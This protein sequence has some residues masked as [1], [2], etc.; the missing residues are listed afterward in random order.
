MHF[1]L[2][3][4]TT[5]LLKTPRKPVYPPGVLVTY[6]AMTFVSPGKENHLA[7]RQV[8]PFCPTRSPS[9][10]TVS[11]SSPF[12]TP[13]KSVIKGRKRK[14]KQRQFHRNCR[15]IHASYR[16][17]EYQRKYGVIKSLSTKQKRVEIA[18]LN[19]IIN[20]RV[21]VQ[22]LKFICDLPLFLWIGWETTTSPSKTACAF[23]KLS[24]FANFKTKQRQSALRPALKL[25]LGGEGEQS[26]CTDLKHIVVKKHSLMAKLRDFF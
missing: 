5:P 18:M 23:D 26:A 15:K 3:S 21:S 25:Y 19:A 24:T 14:Q 11:L 2:L 4:V 13:T 9:A 12:K 22:A 20:A 16:R 8:S 10:N 1:Q 7:T 6:T 17:S